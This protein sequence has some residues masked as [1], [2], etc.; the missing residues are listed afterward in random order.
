MPVD[1]VRNWDR[2]IA[3]H[4]AGYLLPEIWPDDVAIRFMLGP[5]AGGPM[6]GVIMP[7][8][9]RAGRRFPLTIAV[10]VSSPG[11]EIP[12]GAASW[13]EAVEHTSDAARFEGTGADDFAGLLADLPFPL[14]DPEGPSI[15]GI[16]F[17][18]PTSDLIA[19]DP[20]DPRSAMDELLAMSRQ[21]AG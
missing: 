15:E 8:Q 2:W 4:L 9:D 6:A 18:T 13:F 12:Q 3:Q 11:L 14:A 1:F 7:S 16:V 17:W 10:P 21:P 20:N 19:V 5:D